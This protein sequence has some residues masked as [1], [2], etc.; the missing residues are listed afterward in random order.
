M[1]ALKSQGLTRSLVSI[2]VKASTDADRCFN[3]V[4]DDLE[5]LIDIARAKRCRGTN[6]GLEKLL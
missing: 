4:V 5:I 3:W 1:I 6:G 2:L